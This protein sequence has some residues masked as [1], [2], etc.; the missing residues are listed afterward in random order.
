M[1]GKSKIL[2]FLQFAIITFFI[3]DGSFQNDSIYLLIQL[4]ALFIALWGIYVMQLGK[5]NIQPEIKENANLNKKGPYKIIRNPMYLG[6]I[7]FFGVAVIGN[8]TPLRLVLFVVLTIVLLLKIFMEEKFLTKKFQN[9]YI[10]YK[11]ITYRLIPFV[12]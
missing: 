9:E 5:F 4:F 8:Y 1:S 2:V 11:K 3:I 10:Q 6:I 7:L 12:F